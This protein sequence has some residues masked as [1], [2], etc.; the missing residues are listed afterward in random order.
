MPSDHDDLT[1]EQ[2]PDD[3]RG[4]GERGST[5]GGFGASRHLTHAQRIERV[6]A[7]LKRAASNGIWSAIE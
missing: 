3:P 4:D 6:D 5:E 1:A 2:P 7:Y